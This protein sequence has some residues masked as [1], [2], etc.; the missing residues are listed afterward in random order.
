M[1]RVRAQELIEM[2]IQYTHFSEVAESKKSQGK[3]WND[4]DIA[5]AMS[6]LSIP[7]HVASAPPPIPF[8]FGVPSLCGGAF[9][10]A[11]KDDDDCDVL[12]VHD[13]K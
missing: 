3:R 2:F 11:L 13:K 9:P 4:V 6:K 5:Q 8:S 1:S 7:R 10:S 12:T